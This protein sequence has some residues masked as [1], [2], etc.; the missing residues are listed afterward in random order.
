MAA[1]DPSP[2]RL[3]GFLTD[4][5]G[6]AGLRSLQIL[7][8]VTLAGAAIYGATQ[9]KLVVV[10]V[11]VALI[12]AS[13]LSPVV[14]WLRRHGVGRHLSTWITLLGSIVVIGG[15]ITLI[16]ISIENQWA[17]LVKKA[18]TGIQQLQDY[19]QGLNLPIDDSGL[20]DVQEKVTSFLT[21][22]SFGTG[23]LAGVSAATSLVT[24]AVLVVVLLY[25]FLQDGDRMWS[26]FLRP[27]RGERLARGQRIGAT[28]VHTLGGY[29]RGTALV[30]AVDAIVI[31][32]ALVILQ[33]PLAI[34]L[35]IIVFIGAFIPIV[36]ATIAGVLAALIGLVTNGLT[37]AI[38]IGAV[39]ILVNQLEGNLLQPVVMAQS[40]KLHPLV[41][42]V[43]LTAGTIL[44]GI[45]GAVLAVPIT[46]V[47]WQIVKTWDQDTV[48]PPL[49]PPV[50][51]TPVRRRRRRPRII[52]SR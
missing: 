37:V 16:V 25:Y 9:L 4:R 27:F 34:P 3:R 12:L 50:P 45:L 2:D 5:L 43:A 46:A 38:I 26:F 23:A 21:S 52:R 33:V 40:V 24:G 22:A 7:L 6:W 28:T 49:P 15:V 20:Q 35:T 42:L 1:P 41:I 32:A 44:A 11:L 47:A 39:V 29:V 31:G 19:V 48:A 18:S 8:I 10:P 51:P 13:A 36:G 17:S 14:S 30:A